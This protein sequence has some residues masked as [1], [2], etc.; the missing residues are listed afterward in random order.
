[1]VVFLGLP[2]PKKDACRVNES[3]SINQASA[4][5]ALRASGHMC[6]HD[7]LLVLMSTARSGTSFRIETPQ[8]SANPGTIGSLLSKH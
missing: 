6:A 5:R 7:L 8:P 2:G 1:M 4:L 3:P